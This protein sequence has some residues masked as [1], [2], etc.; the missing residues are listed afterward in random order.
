[1]IL[2]AWSG[3][4]ELGPIHLGSASFWI[5]QGQSCI[6]YGE[7]MGPFRCT[8]RSAADIA[9]ILNEVAFTGRPFRAPRWN[10]TWSLPQFDYQRNPG[11]LYAHATIPLWSLALL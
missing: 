11:G 5:A 8:L 9:D 6:N 3:R 7:F 2:W 1:M 4:Q 10:W